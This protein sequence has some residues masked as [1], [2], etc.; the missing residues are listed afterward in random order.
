MSADIE[1][2]LDAPHLAHY[3]STAPFDPFAIE[4][5]APGQERYYMAGQWRL[6]WW[7]LRRHR[8]AVVSGA[9]LLLFY[10]SITVSEILAPYN[11]H[12]RNTDFLYAPPQKV[13]LFD[14]GR[15][16]G[17]FVYGLDTG[18]DMETLRWVYTANP[19]KVE[20]IR[21]FCQGDA[22]KFWSLFEVHFH[23]VCPA[24][25]GTLFLFGTDRLGRDMLSRIIYGA[26]V[27]LTI[28]LIGIS[29]SFL[30]GMT[31]GGLAGYYG[32]W[33]DSLIQRLIE[34]IR[35][36]PELPLWMALSAIL[37]R[38]PEQALANIVRRRLHSRVGLPEPWMTTQARDRVGRT[39]EVGSGWPSCWPLN[40]ELA[41]ISSVPMLSRFISIP[42]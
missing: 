33:I 29:I 3:V 6:M 15:F 37:P 2:R 42:P 31:L 5:M 21:F 7:K 19:L 26:R 38:L 18:L 14:Q 4:A 41:R 22:Y 34:V 20:P 10:L 12:T 36:F 32:G 40:I 23:L 11:L 24:E 8:L 35:S 16:V 28:G 13:H 17:P 9:L 1:D 39:T 30:L 25:G 27:S